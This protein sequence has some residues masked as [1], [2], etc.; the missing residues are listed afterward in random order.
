MRNENMGF[1]IFLIIIGAV[2][3][4]TEL[5]VISLSISSLMSTFFKFWPLILIVIGINIIFHG[6]RVVSTITWLAFVVVLILLDVYG[7]RL[8]FN[9]DWGGRNIFFRT[10]DLFPKTMKSKGFID[11]ISLYVLK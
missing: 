6:N 10:H 1:G 9:I 7:G 8:N 4:L 2:L 3:L 11:S 5:N